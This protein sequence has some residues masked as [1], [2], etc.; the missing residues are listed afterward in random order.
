MFFIFF[1]LACQVF[2]YEDDSVKELDIAKVSNSYNTGISRSIASSLRIDVYEGGFRVGHGS[3]NLFLIG[4]KRFVIT[5]AHVV[6]DHQRV[7]LREHNDDMVPAQVIWANLDSDVAILLPLNKLENTTAV[8]YVN[9]KGVNLDGKSLYFCGYPSDYDG[10]LLRGFVSKTGYSRLVMQS[11]AWFGASGS[12]VFDQFGRAVGIV[13][14]IS[15]ELNPFTGMPVF[16]ESVVIVN[17]VY[18]LTRKDILGILKNGKVDSRNP[19]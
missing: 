2:Y 13:H 7:V 11:N 16:I 18:D 19:N 1:I 10:L 14:A 6:G 5:A 9:N 8:S 12:V 3:G 17:R 4:S 15:M